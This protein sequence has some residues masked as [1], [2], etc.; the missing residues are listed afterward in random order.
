[1]TGPDRIDTCVPTQGTRNCNR[2]SLYRIDNKNPN[3][4]NIEEGQRLRALVSSLPF[5]VHQTSMEGRI[6][7]INE[8]GLAMLGPEDEKDILGCRICI[9]RVRGGP[10]P[11]CQLARPRRG[12]QVIGV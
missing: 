2:A 5:C 1:M 4:P 9:S 8:G 6:T 11:D 7:S 3:T 12:R 10:R